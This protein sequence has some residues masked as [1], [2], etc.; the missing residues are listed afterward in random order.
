M[1]KGNELRKLLFRLLLLALVILLIA[2]GILFMYYPSYI[3]NRHEV[4]LTVREDDNVKL[5]SC[6]LRCLSPLDLGK[7]SWFYRAGLIRDDIAE[8]APDIVG[9]QEA[10]KW[11]YAY[12]CES[13]PQYDSVIEYRDDSVIAEG[14]PI[15]YRKDRFELTDKGSFWL[16]ETPEVMSK[17][18]GAAH[19]R[20][21]SYLILRDLDNGK[22]MLVFN[23]HLDHVSDEARIKGIGVILDYIED[24]G[25]LPA[26]IMGDLNAEE[27]SETYVSVTENFIDAAKAAEQSSGTYTYQNWG[28][29]E[30]AVRIDYFMVSQSGFKIEEYSVLD[31]EHNGVYSS[32][33]CPIMTEIDFKK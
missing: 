18:W 19:Y 1:K 5:M 7:K 10:T 17:D 22:E 27:G 12:L 28:N 13:F 26:V 24:F 23:S 21:C 6:N 29:M 8:Q 32:D 14:C 3:S 11:Q 2:A 9:F 15:F 4:E 33:H 16:S 25:S 31:A 30:K 20:I